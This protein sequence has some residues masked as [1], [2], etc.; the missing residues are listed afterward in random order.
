MQANVAMQTA[1]SRLL[2][3]PSYSMWFKSASSQWFSWLRMSWSRSW[4]RSQRSILSKVLYLVSCVLQDWPLC[5][6]LLLLLRSK[7]P[8]TL[9]ERD[10]YLDSG[11][12]NHIMP[13]FSNLMDSVDFKGF[14]K[15]HIGNGQGL[16]ICHVGT[17]KVHSPFDPSI[18]LH[19]NNLLHVL[20]IIKNLMSVSRLA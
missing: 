2:S 20:H 5:P 1:K 17:S 18:T 12:S 10:W 9:L 14:E 19:L 13:E 7:F 16:S 3:S 11:A 15:L 6:I 4:I 8:E